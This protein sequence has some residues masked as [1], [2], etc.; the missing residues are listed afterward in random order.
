M[1]GLRGAAAVMVMAGG[2][3]AADAATLNLL[4]IANRLVRVDSA[5][6]GTITSTVLL[7]GIIENQ[8]LLGIDYRPASS[9]VLYGVSITGQLYSINPLNGSAAA[10]GAPTPIFG[11]AGDIDFNPSVD[12]IRLVTNTNTNLRLNPDTGALAA[13]DTP[14]AYAAGD[15]G[16]GSAP[17]VV[18]AAYTNN[19]PGGTPTTLYVIDA[20]RGVLATQGSVGSAPVSPNSGQ[21]FTV[22]A[23]GVRT[24]DSAGF[25]I[26][27]DGQVFA[28]FTQP[29]TGTTSLYSVNLTTGAAT[30]IGVV[31]SAGQTYKG[32]AIAPPT[33]ASYG[34]TANQIIV[35]GALEN[36]VGA[37]SAA[38]NTAFNGLD[39]LDAAGRAAALSQ[40]TPSAYSLLPQITLQTVEFEEET[41]RRYLRDF[42][43]GGTGGSAGAIAPAGRRIGGFIV[44][45]GR[46]GRFDPAVDRARVKYSAT[47]VQAGLDARFGE[48]SLIGVTGGYD[49]ARPKFGAA[50]PDSR[51][52][53]YFGG[54]YGT[55]AVG[56]VYIDGFAT[57]GDADY[58]LRRSVNFAQTALAFSASTKSKTYAGGGTA[59]LIVKAGAVEIEPFAGARYAK[60]KVRGFG[61][62]DGFAALSFG[63]ASY[64][65]VIG[66]AG[67]RLG[68]A[69]DIGGA[70]V[71]PEVRGAYRHEFRKDFRGNLAYGF[72]GVGA[73][74][75]TFT[76]T[77]T[78]LRRNYVTGGA[79]LTVSG[80]TSPVALVVDYTG[81]YDKDRR[82]HG[83]TG[84]LR[85]SF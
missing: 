66:T 37:P 57:Y 79:G 78:P 80:A 84:G 11:T 45:S 73:G 75:T 25:D 69:F 50:T 72:G 3:S 30:L 71:R 76:F 8:T 21:L 17:R 33:I 20:N 62:G 48:K 39:S 85:Y 22:G 6:P 31:G 74:T 83:I 47:S 5:T 43:A 81:Q 26:S 12:R 59:G 40:L 24:N 35:G 34:T 10:I 41:I 63:R 44:A 29:G 65:S 82:I 49:V 64:E 16:A 55:L 27:R 32:L 38:L 70:V 67:L 52:E 7:T 42:R 9:R 77:P 68:G 14:L 61:E 15:A 46:Y 19:V 60:L 56:P 2:A 54:A 28:T 23:L 1:V 4:G 58:D 36:F 13:T 18:A 51:I 53:T